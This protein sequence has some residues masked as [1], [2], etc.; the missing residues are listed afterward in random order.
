[1]T[2]VFTTIKGQVYEYKC[3][4][5]S[6]RNET[7]CDANQQ[8]LNIT[9]EFEKLSNDNSIDKLMQSLIIQNSTF[10][11]LPENCFAD[12]GF[13]SIT[14]LGAQSLSRIHTKAFS[15]KMAD[16][17]IHKL[18]IENPSNLQNEPEDYDLFKALNSLK[19]MALLEIS[20]K[21]LIF[22]EIPDNAFNKSQNNLKYLS[23]VASVPFGYYS[24]YGLSRI[25]S[26]SF[27]GLSK[28]R[29]L[30]FRNIFIQNISS[31]AFRIQEKSDQLLS[32]N[33]E[34]CMLVDDSLGND[35]FTGANRPVI[36]N[37]G[38]FKQ[39]ILFLMN[40]CNRTYI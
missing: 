35:S 25:G 1:M 22:H 12:L 10:E 14:I 8:H 2:A 24:G 21:E 23:F 34:N 5:L 9:L 32:I 18:T 6:E 20:L 30:S 15:D 13:E 28:L 40:D 36:V 27:I 3:K 31:D 19:N 4:V 26:N 33:L 17:L 16:T 37:L 38:I 7:I 11:E 39:Y 29:S